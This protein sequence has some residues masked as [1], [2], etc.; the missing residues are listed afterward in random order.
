MSKGQLITFEGGDGA[1]KTT[2]IQRIAD[3]LR[4]LGRHVVL[5]REPGGCPF[6]EKIRDIL[7]HQPPASPLVPEAELALFLA[8][9]AQNIRE[10]IKPALDRGETVLCDRFHHSSIAYQGAGRG[11]GTNKVK[12]LCFAVCGDLWPDMTFY[13][14]LDPEIGK[15]RKA[16]GSEESDRI[17]SETLAFHSRVRLAYQKMANEDVVHMRL[18]DASLPKEVL[19]QSLIPTVSSL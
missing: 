2:L 15:Q 3:Y 19:F 7:L 13:L 16:L 8:A 11:L 17:E 1:G 9:R 5:T 12:E 18:L 14:D 10:V 6:G 4:G